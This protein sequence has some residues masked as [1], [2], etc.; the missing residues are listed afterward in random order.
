MYK[1]Q[2]TVIARRLLLIQQSPLRREQSES[3]AS[4]VLMTLSPDYD[5]FCVERF[6]GYCVGQ[7]DHRR[8]RRRRRRDN[9]CR[10]S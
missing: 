6:C 8:S 4:A 5:D 10:D 9:C 2:T 3:L 7:R 1:Y